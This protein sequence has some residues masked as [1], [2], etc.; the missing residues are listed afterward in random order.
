M[1]N[2]ELKLMPIKQIKLA[3]I[4]NAWG[5]KASPWFKKSFKKQI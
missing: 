3:E 4:E 1:Q 5:F 2:S